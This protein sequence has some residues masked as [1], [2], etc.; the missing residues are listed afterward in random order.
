MR[1]LATRLAL[2]ALASLFGVSAVS[3]DL[4]TY[5]D[6]SGQTVDFVD[7]CEDTFGG[8]INFGQPGATDDVLTFTGFGFQTIADN[9]NSIDLDPGRV[10][11][12]IEAKDGFLIDGI[13]VETVGT[14]FMF[15]Q[16]ASTFANTSGVA[17]V[18]GEI[19]TAN[20]LM[21]QNGTG[22]AAWSSAFEIAFEDA[23]R[24]RMVIDTQLFSAALG[25]NQLSLLNTDA[26]SMR[27]S[28]FE[29]VSVP[30]PTMTAFVVL[31][32]GVVVCNRRR[33]SLVSSA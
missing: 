22:G 8:D 1:K 15:G 16:E 31:F 32:I 19:Y 29:A 20:D 5:G 11:L 12:I 21:E 10:E 14:Y 7:I 18:N 13:E 25:V 24:I 17:E 6:I 30:E 23:D 3:G 4:V 33:R 27:V 9:G 26:I 2:A 28:T